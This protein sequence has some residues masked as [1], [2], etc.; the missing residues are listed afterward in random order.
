[1]S[2]ILVIVVL[3]A[4]AVP[5]STPPPQTDPVSLGGAVQGDIRGDDGMS[6][7]GKGANAPV[8]QW[9]GTSGYVSDGVDPDSGDTLMS[10]TWCVLYRSPRGTPPAAGYPKVKIMKGATLI[11][12]ATMAADGWAGGPDDYKAGRRYTYARTLGDAGTDYTYTFTAVDQRGRTATPLSGAGPTVYALP[13][14]GWCS[15]WTTAVQPSEGDPN[16]VFHYCVAYT[17]TG[18]DDPNA[19]PPKVHIR[20]GGSEISGSP[21]TTTCSG[22]AAPFACEYDRTLTLGFDYTA[23][24]E[25]TNRFGHTVSFPSSPTSEPDVWPLPTLSWCTYWTSGVQPWE[26]DPNTNFHYCVKY[27]PT[28]GDNPTAYAP[29]VHIWKAGTEISGSP[30]PM[31]CTGQYPP[32]ACDKYTYLVVGP[33]YTYQFEVTNRFGSTVRYP[34]PPASGPAVNALPI[35]EWCTGWTSGVDPEQGGTSTLFHY[36]VK[37]T[38]TPGDPPAAYPPKVHIWKGGNALPGSPFTMSCVAPSPYA[39]HYYTTL[40]GGSGYTYQFQVTNRFGSTVRHPIPPGSGPAV[41]PGLE[42]C[43]GWSD[44]IDPDEGDTSATFHYCVEYTPVPGDDPNAYPPEVHIRKGGVEIPGSPFAM[45]C[46]GGAAPY[47]CTYDTSLA[48]GSYTYQFEVVDS[49]GSTTILPSSPAS[50]PEVYD[51]PVLEWCTGW[52][53][54]VDPTAGDPSTTFWYCVNYTPT[55]GDDPYSSPPTL[56]V[57]KGGDSYLSDW[58][59]CWYFDPAYECDYYTMLVEGTDYTYQF[60]ITNRYGSTVRHPIPPGDGPLVREIPIL[61]WCAGWSAGVDPEEGNTSTVFQYCV[62]YTPYPG[63]DPGAYPPVVHV[64]KEDVEIDGS[65]FTTSCSGGGAPYECTYE[66]TLDLGAYSYQFEVTD[67]T[68]FTV[69]FPDPAGFGPVVFVLWWCMGWSAGVSPIEGDPGTLF[70][71]CVRY[72]PT[73]GD[74]PNTYAPVVHIWKSGTEIDGSPFTTSC[75]GASAPYE[76]TYE[77][78]LDIGTY[79][80]QFEVTDSTGS[81]VLFPDPA[82]DG[83][84][85]YSLFWCPGWSEGVDPT[86]GYEYDT[87]F[88]YCVDYTPL[89]GDDPNDYPPLVHIWW[90]DYDYGDWYEIDG[91][92]FTMT[93]TGDAAPYACTYET[94]LGAGSY[95]YQF[96]VTDSSGA[97]TVFPD[98]PWYGPEVYYYYGYGGGGAPRAAGP[99]Q[100]AAWVA[101]PISFRLRPEG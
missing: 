7:R 5:V 74:D 54:G 70:Q 97:T 51:L 71:Y 64:W 27:D 46:S 92:P 42:W 47:E 77:T 82:A 8:L 11:V 39:C 79:S 28:T 40:I 20:K 22:G 15:G 14:L 72:I 23:Q 78:N 55:P 100:R 4:M 53:G 31:A 2:A 24:F 34:I 83:P 43:T 1:M 95:Q 29:K 52:T 80:Y 90:Y 9:C 26:G 50:G 17:P 13:V 88:T 30:F 81:T 19:Y 6:T 85:V 16:T 63:D 75:T 38:P 41:Y 62:G 87:L 10:F 84:T 36:C 33:G 60:E 67:S 45:G 37:Y 98:Y 89:P 44:G 73:P 32:F 18:G 68:G 99:E 94:Y 35:L 57:W 49:T 93:C 76:C 66:T 65:P 101:L 96:E 48:A 21:F 59:S 86:W 91:S 69:W 25:V 56:N 61:D 12:E 3:S 58:M